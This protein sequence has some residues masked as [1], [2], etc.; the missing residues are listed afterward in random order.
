MRPSSSYF[1]SAWAGAN[2]CFLFSR[3]FL[4]GPS[5]IH[6]YRMFQLPLVPPE[7]FPIPV[8]AHSFSRSFR[9]AC[10]SW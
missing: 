6:S 9:V 7:V 3:S 5:I 1:L 4:L 8:I 10:L 2:V